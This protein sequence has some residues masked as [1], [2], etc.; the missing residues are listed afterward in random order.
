MSNDFELGASP[1]SWYKMQM[2]ISEV[3]GTSLLWCVVGVYAHKE[4]DL[5]QKAK[6]AKLVFAAL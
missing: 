4:F 5:G 1:G 6:L 3:G 2:A